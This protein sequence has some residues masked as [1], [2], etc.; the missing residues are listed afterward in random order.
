MA[1]VTVG[2]NNMLANPASREDYLSE[3]GF[4]DDIVLDAA[5][6]MC[7]NPHYCGQGREL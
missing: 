2:G 6:Q 7:N 1:G 4:A 5:S 3:R